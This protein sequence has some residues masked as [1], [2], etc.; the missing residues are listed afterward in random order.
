MCFL[1]LSVLESN[2]YPML[3][4]E[5]KLKKDWDGFSDGRFGKVIVVGFKYI[6]FKTGLDGTTS[7]AHVGDATQA[8]NL[9]NTFLL[10]WINFRF[11]R[12]ESVF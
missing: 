5:K 10:E 8:G 9:I 11:N 3:A 1:N 7:L 4:R 12:I 6:F 2:Y